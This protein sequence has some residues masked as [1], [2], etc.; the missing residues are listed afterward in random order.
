[1][2]EFIARI[3]T[4][5]GAIFDDLQLRLGAGRSGPSLQQQT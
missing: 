1:M 3:G 4:P 2:P 5:D